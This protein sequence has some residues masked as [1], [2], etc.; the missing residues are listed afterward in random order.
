MHV[1]RIHYWKVVMMGLMVTGAVFL[2][3]SIGQTSN[4]AI[5]NMIFYEV[6]NDIRRTINMKLI[7]KSV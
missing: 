1:Q 6:F 4:N 2:I 7:N 3:A 5:G